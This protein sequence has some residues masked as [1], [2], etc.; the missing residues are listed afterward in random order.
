VKNVRG[1]SRGNRQRHGATQKLEKLEAKQLHAKAKI[2][3]KRHQNRR[4]DKTDER[5]KIRTE[6]S[7]E[8]KPY[9]RTENMLKNKPQDTRRTILR[10]WQ[11]R[12]QQK[13]KPEDNHQ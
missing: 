10:I 4:G 6:D 8:D 9:S 3:A 7:P 2:G 1:Q 13:S 5:P 12:G 11:D